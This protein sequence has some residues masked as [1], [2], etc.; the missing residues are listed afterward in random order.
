MLPR[1]P[2]ING[3]LETFRLSTRNR[4]PRM[5]RFD[6]RLARLFLLG[7]VDLA[8]FDDCEHRS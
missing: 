7:D 4:R 2:A 5:P 8:V 3:H 6:K 1:L